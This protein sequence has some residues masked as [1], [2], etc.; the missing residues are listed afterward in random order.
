[1][2]NYVKGKEK[3]ELE[4]CNYILLKKSK[5]TKKIII[6]TSNIKRSNTD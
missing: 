3:E 4:E 6:L 1:L 2:C 5:Q